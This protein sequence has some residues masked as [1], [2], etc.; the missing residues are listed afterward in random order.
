MTR[1][2]PDRLIAGMSAAITVAI[3]VTAAIVSRTVEIAFSMS[4]PPGVAA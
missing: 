1:A 4:V 2:W 3:A